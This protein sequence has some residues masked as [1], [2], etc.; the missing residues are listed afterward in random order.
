VGKMEEDPF[1]SFDEHRFQ[2]SFFSGL[3]SSA[4]VVSA[5]RRLWGTSLPQ[6]LQSRGVPR[7]F[8]TTMYSVSSL[9]FWG[10]PPISL[11]ALSNEAAICVG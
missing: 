7:Y 5:G 4:G 1:A 9:A 11:P 10:S 2:E 8:S 3:E 6:I